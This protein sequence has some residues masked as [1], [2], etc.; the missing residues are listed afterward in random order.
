[1]K[2]RFT[3]LLTLT[4]ALVGCGKN[5]SS[6]KI[7]VTG[8]NEAEP[9]A[10]TT[11]NTA[12]TTP[13]AVP[14]HNWEFKEGDV[15]GYIAAVSEEDRKRGKAAGDVIMYRYAGIQNGA[16]H[17]E[18]VRDDGTIESTAACVRPCV[19]IKVY[20]GAGMQRIAYNPSSIIGAAFEDAMNGRLAKKQL[21]HQVRATA[22]VSEPPAAEISEQNTVE[23]LSNSY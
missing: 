3:T 4:A 23:W 7:Q 16:Y 14:T 12:S 15:Y 19:A 6:P 11:S 8:S 5:D 20:S 17:L 2:L 9:I 10:T 1:M 18:L 21:P 22:S 13:R